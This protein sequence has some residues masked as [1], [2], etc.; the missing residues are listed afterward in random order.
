MT[1]NKIVSDRRFCTTYSKQKQFG[2]KQNKCMSSKSIQ[3][4]NAHNQMINFQLINYLKKCQKMSNLFYKRFEENQITIPGSC[5]EFLIRILFPLSSPSF[6]TSLSVSEITSPSL[7]SSI[8][9]NNEMECREGS[10]VLPSNF[11]AL[12]SNI[13]EALTYC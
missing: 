6:S 7:S 4:S 1:W 5:V 12:A 3:Y 13:S 2:A 8:L 11:M 10:E 9:G